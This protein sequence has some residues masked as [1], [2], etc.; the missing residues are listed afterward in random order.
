MTHTSPPSTVLVTGVSSG[1]GHALAE[2]L[3]ADGHTVIGISRR[4]PEALV[5]NERFRFRSVDLA[6][7]D[8]VG[9]ALQA[10]I[11]AGST[12]D[13]VVLNAGVLGEIRDLAK[14]PLTDMRGLMEVN[15]WSNKVLLEA[16][17]ARDVKTPQVVAISSGAAVKG[18]R[19]WG[20]YAVSKAA[21]NMLVQVLAAERPDV[22]FTSLA[23]GLVDT[24]MQKYIRSLPDAPEYASLER[25]KAAHGTDA[26]PSAEGCAAR[27]VPLF[28][29]LLTQPSGS[30]VDVR[31]LA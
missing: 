4:R 6:H 5:K 7:H 16:L 21:L 23:P 27:M 24:D 22:H 10:L 2:R 12:V 17:W 19:G 9:P 13:L 3:L 8:A 29:K 30:F 15:V 18:N 11:P 26:M 14:T 25:L 1:I 31:N 28:P 20:A